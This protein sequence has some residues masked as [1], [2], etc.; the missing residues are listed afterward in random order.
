MVL[1]GKGYPCLRYGTYMDRMG[2]PCGHYLDFRNT[3]KSHNM[4][5]GPCIHYK[6]KVGF[7]SDKMR[8]PYM[9]DNTVYA[10]TW[11]IK[12]ETLPWWCI[13]DFDDALPFITVLA[14]Q[15][16]FVYRVTWRQLPKKQFYSLK[17]QSKTLFSFTQ[18]YL[19]M[20]VV[21]YQSSFW[22]RRTN[23][24]PGKLLAFNSI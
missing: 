14:L 9:R 21:I 17:C 2:L 16:R 3:K 6:A 24:L 10:I 12:I 19:R 20:Y 7:I 13:S 8:R 5:T 23:C 15:N 11:K 22:L 4:R 1:R 18:E